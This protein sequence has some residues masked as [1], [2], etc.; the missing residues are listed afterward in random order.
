MAR[1]ERPS[2]ILVYWDKQDPRE[3]GWAWRAI[4]YDYEGE[5]E[6]EES[7]AIEGRRNLS[8]KT[9]ER[10]ARKEAGFAGTRIPVEIKD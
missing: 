7:G 2:I 3:P 5:R 10:R 6:H 9:L 4:Y 8:T 1:R